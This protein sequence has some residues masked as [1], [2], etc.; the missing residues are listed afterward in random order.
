MLVSDSWFVSWWTWVLIQK[1]SLVSGSDSPKQMYEEEEKKKTLLW[2]SDSSSTVDS[3]AGSFP[4]FS[5]SR[6]CIFADF[7]I[8]ICFEFAPI[9]LTRLRDQNWTIKDHWTE[10]CF[11]FSF[12]W[13]QFKT[14]ASHL[15]R[16]H[17]E[18]WWSK[19]V[20]REKKPKPLRLLLRIEKKRITDCLAWEGH[21]CVMSVAYINLYMHFI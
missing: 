17:V 8:Y 4:H 7:Y 13:V 18:K 10:K 21:R 3:V 6:W 5:S 12:L 11:F 9:E 16:V 20:M 14:D 1:Q 15:F 19:A 2:F